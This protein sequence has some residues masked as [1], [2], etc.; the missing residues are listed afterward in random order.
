MAEQPAPTAPPSAPSTAAST[1][2]PTTS[3]AE[4][5]PSTAAPAQPATAQ[6]PEAPLDR[7]EAGKRDAL[8]RYSVGDSDGAFVELRQL[9]TSCQ[10]EAAACSAT[11]RASLF[12]ALGIVFEGALSDDQAAIRSFHTALVLDP[13]AK[14]VPEYATAAIQRDFAIAARSAAAA[15]S[16]EVPALHNPSPYQGGDDTPHGALEAEPYV[17][18]GADGT[19]AE[20]RDDDGLPPYAERDNKFVL[21][22]A[23]GG[24][25]LIDE[26]LVSRDG[27]YLGYLGEQFMTGL[28][29][30]M[31]VT[32]GRSKFAI[33]GRARLGILPGTPGYGVHELIGANVMLGAIYGKRQSDSFGYLLGG[34]GLDKG[35]YEPLV[36]SY[37][38]AGFC[39]GGFSFGANFEIASGEGSFSALLLNLG[40]GNL[41]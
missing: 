3:P 34:I 13:K 27:E 31:G 9:I 35:R 36:S 32:P 16:G 39:V 24:G 6:P 19:E 12:V 18:S 40:Y 29:V 2:G 1:T 21:I 33:G 10:A 22:H 5:D 25:A 23:L 4:A 17:S 26:Y 41:F 30:T 37:G 15:R 14:L 8:V 7:F 38:M 11:T 28:S 20:E